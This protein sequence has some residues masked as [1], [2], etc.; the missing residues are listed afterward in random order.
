MLQARKS[1]LEAGAGA[2]KPR[3]LQMLL[4]P[5]EAAGEQGRRSVPE[6]RVLAGDGSPWDEI[7]ARDDRRVVPFVPWLPRDGASPAPQMLPFEHRSER[8]QPGWWKTHTRFRAC[9]R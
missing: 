9:T 6:L 2:L 7:S 5:R 4:P 3:T 1:L 8:V